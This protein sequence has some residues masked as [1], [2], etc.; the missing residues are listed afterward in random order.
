MRS[1]T[2]PLVV[3]AALAVAGCIPSLQPLYT[4]KTTTIDP[5][6]V[7]LWE[8]DNGDST[9]AFVQKET[10]T[11]GLTYTDKEGKPGQF[12]VRL[13]KLGNMYFLDLFPEDPQQGENAYYK[14]HL[15]RIHTFLKM[16][17]D[18][19]TLQLAGMDPSWLKRQLDADPAIVRHATVNNMIVF[20]ASSE[21]LQQFVR[22]H[23]DDKDA[24]SI[25]INLTRR[26][27]AAVAAADK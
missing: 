21:E 3:G 5:A 20:T 25:V 7:G 9:W 27:A 10:N 1:L 8:Q 19:S 26:D 24:F 4:D 12:E 18:G 22:R 15:L 11:Y 14:F 16:S 6:L 13:V 23:A 2:F 17:L